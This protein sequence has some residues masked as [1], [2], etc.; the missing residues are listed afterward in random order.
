MVREAEDKKL[1]FLAG[2]ALASGDLLSGKGIF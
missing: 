2:S 1:P